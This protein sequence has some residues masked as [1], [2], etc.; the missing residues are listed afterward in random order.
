MVIEFENMEIKKILQI[1]EDHFKSNE[2]KINNL[3][4]FPV[5]DGDTGTNMLL[6]LK[7]I[8][9]ELSG[10]KQFNVRETGEAISFGG[11]MGARGN[12]GVILSQ[13][14]KGFFDVLTAEDDFDSGVLENALN[15][16]KNLAYNSV[17]NPTEG[18][19]LTIIKDLYIYIR[20]F[21]TSNNNNDISL[22]EL[23]DNLISETEKSLIR[24]T[25]LLP[26]LKEANVVDAGAQGVLEILKGLKLAMIETN[27]INGK[28]KV[29]Q[30]Q[31]VQNI[32]TEIKE[33][34][35]KLKISGD[36][37]GA[38]E[39]EDWSINSDIKFI[40][41]TE[42]VLTGKQINI[43]R[44]KEDIESLG[45]SAMVVG[46]E[47]LVKVHVHSNNPNKILARALKEGVLH[48]IEIKNMV[49]QNKE[50]MKTQMAAVKKAPPTVGLIS[51]SNGEGIEQ[52]F[53]SIG[54][55]IVIR[56]GQTMNPSTYEVVRAI[57]K[58]DNEKILIF[59]N[60]KNIILTAAQAAKISKRDVMV[61]PTRTIPQ[62]I[63]AVLNFNKDLSIEENMKN[64][65]T[66]YKH[67][68]SG[69]VTK[70][71]RDANLLVGEIKKGNFIGLYDGKIKVVS[72][73]AHDATMELIKD[74]AG[75]NDSIITF[76]P[77]RDAKEEDNLKIKES[78]SKLY[79]DLDIE[80][81][82]GN[83]PFYNYIFSIE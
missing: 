35:E 45:D 9:K 60:N 11:L 20:N 18:T 77:G 48:E 8:K 33:E 15:S 12:S 69:E 29:A 80:F 28:L 53:K 37:A 64:M 39:I 10:L 13:I 73:N 72:D 49:D 2:A 67:I 19:M 46:T 6:T 5:P 55:D 62:G 3:N 22:T 25:F 16:A 57:K 7:S 44:L 1:I 82:N 65:E 43:A 36:L 42:F 24:T 79:P 71:V 74:M 52:I 58:L 32:R 26:V 23:M 68:K 27:K 17:Q 41:C 34:G 66:A 21:N 14:L 75:E 38:R 31:E 76:Y 81:L 50:K 59:P 70:A 4:V 30:F 40:Y 61:I 83:Q 47:N 51:V 78:I 63:S 56:G 54:V